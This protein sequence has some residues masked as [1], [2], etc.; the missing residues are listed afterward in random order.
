MLKSKFIIVVFRSKTDV[1]T[2]IGALNSLGI[3]ASTAGTPKEAEI[4]CGIAVRT[5][6]R[7]LGT[8]KS[9]ISVGYDS[10]YGIYL[11]ES[12]GLRTSRT[13]IA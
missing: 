8:V 11:V 3:S 4:G 6:Y 12:S 5:E 13:R 1:F 10:F 2:L 9:L 7:H